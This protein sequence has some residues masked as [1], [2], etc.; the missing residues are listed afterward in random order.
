V[1]LERN[2]LDVRACKG[3]GVILSVGWF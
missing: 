1:E 2:E 3:V